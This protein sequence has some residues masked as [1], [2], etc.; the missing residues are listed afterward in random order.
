M[1]PSLPETETLLR[2][3]LRCEIKML[4]YAAKPQKLNPNM[5]T[6]VD[7]WDIWQKIQYDAPIDRT[8][9]ADGWTISDVDDFE[10]RFEIKRITPYSITPRQGRQYLLKLG[11]TDTIIL[12]ALN[13]LPSPKKEVAIIEWE[14]STLFL[15]NNPLVGM[16][17]QMIGWG[18]EQLDNM[19]IEASKL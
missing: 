9:I 19:W 13:Q 7:K 17:G 14:F 5:P 12:N 6:D 15:R 3:R 18:D 4:K 1:G 11:L 10:R 16:I 2:F 8:L